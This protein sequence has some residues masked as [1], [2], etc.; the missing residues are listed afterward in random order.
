MVENSYFSTTYL[1]FRKANMYNNS[2]AL[3]ATF[4]RMGVEFVPID[5]LETVETTLE[6]EAK[7][8][9]SLHELAMYLRGL[10]G[11]LLRHATPEEKRLHM[12]LIRTKV[13]AV[14]DRLDVTQ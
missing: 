11:Q 12:R 1:L 2:P 8:A 14:F 7:F 6:S 4:R 3:S 9:H 5:V 13:A 10:H